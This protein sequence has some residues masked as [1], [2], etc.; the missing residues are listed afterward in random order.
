MGEKCTEIPYYILEK[1]VAH[2]PEL[3]MLA[4]HASS[5]PELY[6][7]VLARTYLEGESLLTATEES[8]LA[9]H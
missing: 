2:R 3:R 1:I 9:A 5:E 6:A 8:L 4:L 7:K